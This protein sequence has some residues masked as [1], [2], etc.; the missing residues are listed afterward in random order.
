MTV[1]GAK[2]GSVNF[3]QI[4]ALLG[5]QE[6]EGRR[7]PRMASGKTLPCFSPWDT[8]ARAGG[9]IADRFLD[10]IRP[11][12][13]YFH[14]MAGREGLVDTAVKTSRSGYLQRCMVKNLEALSVAYDGTVR[15]GSDGAVVQFIY[16]EDGTDVT[17]TGYAQRFHFLAE[18]AAAVAHSLRAWA[19]LRS[20]PPLGAAAS[21]G[22]FG[23]RDLPLQARLRPCAVGA[24]GEAYGAALRA[25]MAADGGRLLAQESDSD[26]EDLEGR[27]TRVSSAAFVRLMELRHMRSAAAPGEAVGVIAA[28]SVGEPSTQM[29]LNTFHFA[30]RGEANVT[31]GIPRL[32]ELLMAAAR[33]IGTPVMTLPMAPAAP[34]G[35]EAAARRLAASLR[36]VTLAELLEH[37]EL[38]ERPFDASHGGG[39]AR[40]YTLRAVVR[41]EADP[42][43]VAAGAV[44]F[45]EAADAFR[46]EFCRLFYGMVKAELR[47]AA[48]D[49]AA[50]IDSL[51]AA[52]ARRPAA[53]AAGDKDDEA[54]EPAPAEA[55]EE[56]APGG[57][58]RRRRADAEVGEEPG[59]DGDGDEDE[60]E[61][62]A[63][64]DDRRAA[65]DGEAFTLPA[66]ADAA[67]RRSRRAPRAAAVA[68]GGGGSDEEAA[69]D[70]EAE[71]E[72][73]EEDE[74]AAEEE[75]EAMPSAR[76]G[77]RAVAAAAGAHL[78]T[79]LEAMQAAVTAD[80]ASRTL[81]ATLHLRL[82]APNVLMLSLAQRAASRAAVRATR[83]I[84]RCYVLPP[85][86]EQSPPLGWRVQTDGINFGAAFSAP[87][88][89]VD[90]SAVSSNDVYAVL[91]QYGCEAARATL[92]A[93]VR[94][95]FGAYGIAVDPR[96]LSLIAD[97]MTHTG[98]YRPCSR[99]GIDACPSPLLKMSYETATT[100][101]T[102]AT[103]HGCTDTLHSPSARLVL[104]RLVE[105]GTGAFSLGAS[106]VGGSSASS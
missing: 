2:G 37:F 50:V 53:A 33:R 10:G 52:T 58:A 34:G 6:L 29:T 56:E 14:C 96:H 39:V 60:D 65:R 105:L 22:A 62:G 68:G 12:E 91:L 40:R 21:G 99:A 98:G 20:A 30:G 28:Q 81:T 69:P 80:A 101:L 71:A 3:A 74:E 7:V 88:E 5:Q 27:Q 25:F 57:D 90:T 102:D 47:R 13:Y 9:Y 84:A 38:C 49:E 63:K 46:A 97:A 55:A 8:A 44:G 76:G 11:Q 54:D 106:R 94:A 19:P 64:A 16:G 100:F 48:G 92:L 77:G 86:P 67:A 78:L 1:S 24:V 15:D 31:L 79:K 83:G 103:L 72:M 26:S 82:D 93:E 87:D 95:V 59:D 35:G 43:A 73:D 66:A 85:A 104:G 70:A 18:N 42:A 61:E 23:P 45:E 17:R 32:R 41:T 75:E 89:S 36:R 51:S 4:S